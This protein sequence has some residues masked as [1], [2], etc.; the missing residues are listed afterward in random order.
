MSKF[1]EIF[2]GVF[3]AIFWYSCGFVLT[4]GVTVSAVYVAGI[5]DLVDFTLKVVVR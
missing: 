3:F 5:F 4:T 2:N 1:K